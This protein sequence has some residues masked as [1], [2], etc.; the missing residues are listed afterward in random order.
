MD[1]TPS[2]ST[3]G[4][5]SLILS[6]RVEDTPV[7]NTAGERIGSISDLSID[8]ISGQVVYAIMSFGGFLGLGKQFHPLPWSMLDYDP[9]RQGYVVPINEQDLQDAPVYTAEELA[10]LGGDSQAIDR[11]KL[12]EYYARYGVA[13]PFF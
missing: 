12:Y 4:D 5:R 8:R 10:R 13:A 1:Q 11:A 9:E 7:Y 6:S 2:S 3:P